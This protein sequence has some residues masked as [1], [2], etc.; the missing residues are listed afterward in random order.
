MREIQQPAA[1][2][3]ATAPP[4]SLPA[5]SPAAAAQL[6][7]LQRSAGNRATAQL[8]ARWTMQDPRRPERALSRLPE[9]RPDDK[10]EASKE[11]PWPDCTP[12]P[13]EHEAISAWKFWMNKVGAP[14]RLAKRCNC[15]LVG[16]AYSDYLNGVG[17]RRVNKDDGN[18]I[19]DQCA[20]DDKAHEVLEARLLK[21]WHDQGS[22][23]ES[24]LAGGRTAELDLVKALEGTVLGPQPVPFVQ[25]AT[26]EITFKNNRLAG[27]LLFGGGTPAGETSSDFGRDTR[28]VSGTV[29]LE[30]TDGGENPN[31]IEV[32]E[33]V[34]F[35]YT[36]DDAL[37]FCP[38]NT[39]RK[40]DQ[41]FEGMAYN[42]FL[43]DMSRL[44]ASGMTKDIGFHVE[45]HRT[46]TEN[47]SIRR[48]P[49]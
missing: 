6:L 31:F 48:A 13:F 28:L 19:S 22:V 44:E 26:L 23:A 20:K 42:E 43:S 5:A 45:Y 2:S 47:R 33:T 9:F 38:G 14:D 46:H 7:A 3:S 11:N 8:L 35:N 18:C 24:A 36:V 30:R 16:N 4:R 32:K 29:R 21:E 37:D 15:S 1:E 25:D 49:K 40:T 41:G 17:G 39:T 34:V 27:G 10:Q 12:F